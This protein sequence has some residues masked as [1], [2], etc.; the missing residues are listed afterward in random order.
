MMLVR[1]AGLALMMPV[2]TQS[3]DRW[4]EARWEAIA[5]RPATAVAFPQPLRTACTDCYVPDLMR[6]FCSRRH[7]PDKLPGQPCLSFLSCWQNRHGGSQP[8]VQSRHRHIG[9]WPGGCQLVRPR[10]VQL[11]GSPL[12]TVTPQRPAADTRRPSDSAEHSVVT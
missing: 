2:P 9:A 12:L 11:A 1:T 4:Q 6:P 10:P 7:P 8:G 3:L 5:R